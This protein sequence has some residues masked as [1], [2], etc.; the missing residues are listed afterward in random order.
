M[1]LPEVTELVRGEAMGD[2]VR[3]FLTHEDLSFVSPVWL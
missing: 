2:T 1:N 3:F